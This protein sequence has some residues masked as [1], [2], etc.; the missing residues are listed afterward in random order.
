MS[1]PAD[2]RSQLV[3][4]FDE[5]HVI[6]LVYDGPLPRAAWVAERDGGG[7]VSKTITRNEGESGDDFLDR[8][9]TLARHVTA[10]LSPGA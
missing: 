1:D 7:R 2:L 4:A 5:D 10:S 6:A 8:A 3:E 9:R